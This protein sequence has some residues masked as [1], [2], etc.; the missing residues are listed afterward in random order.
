VREVDE[1]TRFPAAAHTAPVS[2]AAVV[3]RRSLFGL[4]V[5]P[6]MAAAPILLPGAASAALTTTNLTFMVPIYLSSYMY[7][8][9]L[10]FRVGTG[11]SGTVEWGLFD[12]S[13]DPMACVKVA[14]GSGTGLNA[15]GWRQISSSVNNFG[16]R[17]NPGGYALIIRFPSASSPTIHSSATVATLSPSIWRQATGLAWND[18]PD[19]TS[20]DYVGVSS[21]QLAV[22]LYGN[23][24][25]PDGEP[26]DFS[27]SW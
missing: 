26:P 4:P 13:I 27:Y 24:A 10:V 5:T 7:V 3:A 19:L 20:A 17:I 22:W 21:A 16:D 1:P 25:G 12:Y 6:L 23:L 18:T 9:G 14:G 8:A 2:V 15:A 11:N